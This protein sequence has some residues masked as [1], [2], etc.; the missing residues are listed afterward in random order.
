MNRKTFLVTIAALLILTS[1]KK[2][3]Q[4]T[5]HNGGFEIEFLFEH[6]GCKVYRFLDGRMVYF[7]DCR[8]KMD[9]TTTHHNGKTTT[10][11]YHTTLNN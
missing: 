4:E 9:H 6:D 11:D 1:C 7:S 10:T 2:A 3:A 8:G 5:H